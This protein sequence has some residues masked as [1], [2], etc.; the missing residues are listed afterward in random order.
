MT[1]IMIEGGLP[2]ALCKAA[3]TQ[4][5]RN[6]YF[7]I[8]KSGIAGCGAWAA[9]DLPLE[10]AIQPRLAISRKYVALRVEV[11]RSWK[12]ENEA[13]LELIIS[14][15]YAVLRVEVPRP[16]KRD[17]EAPLELDLKYLMA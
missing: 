16:W 2:T 4:P 9:K 15:K 17:D 3:S 1:S 10:A 14:R 6:D 11:S 7:H 8:S 12:R 5:F 13:P